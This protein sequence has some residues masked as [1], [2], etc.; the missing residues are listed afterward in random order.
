MCDNVNKAIIKFNVFCL[1]WVTQIELNFMLKYQITSFWISF[2]SGFQV[3]D[4]LNYNPFRRIV[5][6]IFNHF[7]IIF[8]LGRL[9]IL[10]VLVIICKV[11]WKIVIRTFIRIQSSCINFLILNFHVY[12]ERFWPWEFLA[13]RFAIKGLFPSV[14]LNASVNDMVK[15]HL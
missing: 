4:S 6:D 1:A 7:W 5:S 14:S 10:F 13:T 12:S 8:W 3:S 9:D 2:S 15:K 11:K